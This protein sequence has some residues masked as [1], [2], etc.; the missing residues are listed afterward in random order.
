MGSSGPLP[1][2]YKHYTLYVALITRFTISQPPCT[3]FPI[4]LSSNPRPTNLFG[5]RLPLC[6]TG[7]RRILLGNFGH[8]GLTLNRNPSR[9]RREAPC[10]AKTRVLERV[11]G[12]GKS[13]ENWTSFPFEE[14]SKEYE[15]KG[16]TVD[17]E[18]III[19]ILTQNFSQFLRI[20]KRKELRPRLFVG[21]VYEAGIIR[22]RN[23]KFLYLKHAS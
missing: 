19:I 13:V 18:G 12:R 3:D 6:L 23:N 14:I 22:E 8:L 10:Y 2:L 9:G 1:P 16:R 11:L 21:H 4:F 7:R 5:Y 15:R 20:A 17:K